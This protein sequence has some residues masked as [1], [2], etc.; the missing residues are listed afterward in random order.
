MRNSTQTHNQ[1]SIDS[2]GRNTGAKSVTGS[3]SPTGQEKA[4]EILSK[5][6]G[7]LIE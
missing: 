6:E 4:R 1:Q 5:I 7:K 2:R 3:Y